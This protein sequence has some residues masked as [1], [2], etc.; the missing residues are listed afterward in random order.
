MRLKMF[1]AAVRRFLISDVL[2]D[3]LRRV[4]TDVLRHLQGYKLSNVSGIV[5]LKV[6]VFYPVS[7]YLQRLSVCTDYMFNVQC[8]HMQQNDSLFLSAWWTYV[9]SFAIVYYPRGNLSPHFPPKK[10]GLYWIFFLKGSCIFSWRSLSYQFPSRSKLFY[11][12]TCY[13]RIF[14]IPFN[15]LKDKTFP[16]GY[17]SQS[18]LLWKQIYSKL[19]NGNWIAFLLSVMLYLCLIFKE[20]HWAVSWNILVFTKPDKFPYHADDEWSK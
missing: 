2:M 18:W 7:Q 3:T 6:G 19:W 5:S 14:F 16:S 4:F 20:I 12:V 9:K 1:F 13:C 10:Q 8:F 15:K 17:Y 11:L